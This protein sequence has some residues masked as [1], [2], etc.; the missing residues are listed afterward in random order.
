M[1]ISFSCSPH[2]PTQVQPLVISE[3]IS[4]SKR[5][6]APFL[7]SQRKRTGV[8]RTAERSLQT[9]PWSTGNVI[10]TGLKYGLRGQKLAVSFACVSALAQ[11]GPKKS[12]LMNKIA[13]PGA[14]QP[15]SAFQN[16]RRVGFLKYFKFGWNFLRIV[17]GIL[18]RIA[19]QLLS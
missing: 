19:P 18:L 12:N 15:Y 16:Y 4:P 5:F 10:A 13:L 11:H 17:F 8:L 3:I 7:Q 14:T 9:E 1:W 2:C 6:N